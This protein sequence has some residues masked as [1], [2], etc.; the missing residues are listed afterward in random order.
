MIVRSAMPPEE[1]TGGRARAVARGTLRLLSGQVLAR[2]LDMA[3]YVLLARRLGVDAF[4]AFTYAAS[5]T[6]LFNV[7]TDLGLTTVFTREVSQRPERTRE[8]LAHALTLKLALAPLTLLMV[9]GIAWGMHT[10]PMTLALM[11]LLTVAMLMGSTAGL[12]EGL[13]RAAGR[14]GSVGVSLLLASLAGFG[15]IAGALGG[16]ITVLTAALAHL[17]AQAVHLL[18]TFVAARRV[19]RAEPSPAAANTRLPGRSA[20]LREALPLALSWVFIALYFRIDAVMLYAMQDANAVGLYGG[21]YRVFE[22]F[23]ML[24]VGFR[25]VLFPFMARAADGPGDALATLCRKSL[26][27]QILFTVLVGVS[28]TFFARQIVVLVLGVEYAEAARG[29]AILIWALPGS[30]MA[31]TV[32]HLLVAQR[33]QSL[34]TWVVGGTALLNIGLNLVLIPHWSFVGAAT[35]T[36]V[37]ELTCFTFLYALFRSG[38]PGVGLARVAWR[39]LAAGLALAGALALLVPHLPEGWVG[40]V[41]GLLISGTVYLIVL[42]GVGGIQR[43]DL[44]VLREI[45]PARRSATARAGVAP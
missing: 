21:I 6:L 20:M 41:F 12:Y 39:P 23:A 13:L 4:G 5:F 38:V 1:P 35:A 9:L 14:P 44:R 28:F 18:A 3:L 17:A 29:L 31:D 32:L 19:P 11:G 26:R 16:T 30:Y 25:S 27:L 10:A 24:T 45:L 34:G 36:V 22:A 33:R 43:D 37:C 7:A 15:V 40:L 8:L 2:L 42:L